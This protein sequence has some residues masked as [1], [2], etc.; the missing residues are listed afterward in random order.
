MA[1]RYGPQHRA[2]R[3]AWVPAVARGECSCPR[4]GKP[5]H[6]GQRWDLGHAEG[7]G[8]SDYSGPEHVSCNRAAG[9]R[10]G[11]RMRRR[12]KLRTSEDW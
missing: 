2:L 4:C 8:P 3:A 9:A 10:N 12:L 7:G 11:N 1:E 6:P 5:I